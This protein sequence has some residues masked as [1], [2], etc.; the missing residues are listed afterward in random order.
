MG[1]VLFVARGSLGGF[2]GH[3]IDGGLG[4]TFYRKIQLYTG[5]LIQ[6]ST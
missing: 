6:A 4:G 3:L 1:Y 5:P 2:G